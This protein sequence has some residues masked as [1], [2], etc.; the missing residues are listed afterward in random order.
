MD[1][2]GNTLSLTGDATTV[3]LSSFANTDDQDLTLT[4]NTLSLTNDATT[5]D[6]STYL[7]NTDAQDLT[8]TGNTLSLTGD[9]T[10]V[11]L[12]GFANPDDQDLTLTGN[13]LSLTNDATTVDLSTYLDKYRCA[14]PDLD[15]QYLVAYRRCHDSRSYRLRYTLMIMDLTLTRQHALIN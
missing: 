9:A 14:R 1:L 11:D 3:D 2:T 8:L 6:L 12:T 15:R 10:T 4:G 5:V 7:D 13:T